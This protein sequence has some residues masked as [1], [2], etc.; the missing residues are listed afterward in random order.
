MALSTHAHVYVRLFGGFEVMID[1]HPVAAQAWRRRQAA[2]LVKMLALHR[3]HRMPREQVIDALWPDALVDEAAPRLHKAAHYARAVLGQGS[4]VLADDLVCLFPSAIVQTDVEAFEAAGPEAAI[5]LYRG[6]LLPDDLYEPWTQDARDQ[7]RL[8]YLRLLHEQQ[9][10]EQIVAADPTDEQAHAQLVRD[11][12]A[13]GDRASALRQLD[14]MDAALQRE[15]GLPPSASARAL[16]AE[17]LATPAMDP[18]APPAARGPSPAAIA[19]PATRTIGRDDDVQRVLRLL[20]RC[21][22]VTLLG[23]GGVGKTRLAVE[24]ALAHAANCDVEAAFV[25]LT[26]V[27]DPALV[28]DAIGHALGIRVVPA[29]GAER[30]LAEALRG[31]RMVLVLDNFEHVVDAADVATEV[32]GI[33]PGLQ[34]LVTSRVR[35]RIAGEQVYDVAPLSVEE[36]DACALF[37]QVATALDPAFRLEAALDDVRAICRQVDGLPLAIELAAGHVRTLPPS[38]LRSRLGVQLRSPAGALRAGPARQQTVAA[39]ID[40]SLALLRTAEHR[41]FARMG[42]FTSPVP[43]EAVEAVCAEGVDDAPATPAAQVIES[44]SYLVDS[45]LVRR[46]LTPSTG[47]PRFVLLELLR[48]RARTLLAEPEQQ[49]LALRHARWVAARLDD[50]DERRWSEVAGRWIDDIAELMPEI[51]AAHGWA[52]SSGEH[53]LAA[54][55]TADL[56]TYWHRDGFHGEA[57]PWVATA[58]QRRQDWDDLLVARLLLAAGFLEW[59]RDMLA[60][61]EHWQDAARLFRAH[62]HDRYLAYALALISGTYIGDESAYQ[63][64][65]AL[66]DEAILRARGVGERPLIAQALNVKGEL[67]RVHGDDE[68][69][70]VVYQEGRDLAEAAGDRAHLSMFMANLSYIARHRGDYAEARRLSREALQLCWSLGRRMMAAWTIAELAG[71]DLGTGRPERGARLIGASD[72]ALRTL[73]VARHPGDRPEHERVVE[74]LRAALGPERYE[75][76]H[77]IG[78]RWSLDEAVVVALADPDRVT[79][80]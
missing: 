25:D 45:S 53:L 41:L 20:E 57:R 6:D 74:G 19:R 27:S 16:R 29:A 54:R 23:P 35:L 44:L 55:I 3:G 13:R 14:A 30:A 18:G 58:L 70:L 11:H 17:V 12:L 5:A 64:A 78:A 43:L 75:A 37:E 8:R 24:V 48:D 71:P 34:V 39:T 52:E 28:P 33:S 66:C 42:V 50:I 59:P 49:H 80:P 65:I 10:W 4:L 76:E 69:A 67:A 62:R 56:G 36:G 77:A 22:V 32:V 1:G 72:A 7:H 47:E 21:R 26:R 73:G 9:R 63:T 46:V 31:R 60:A 15:L 40:W 79:T 38:L 51:R 68:T 2:S 61:R